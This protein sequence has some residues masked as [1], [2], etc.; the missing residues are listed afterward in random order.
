[1]RRI[2]ILLIVTATL[3]LSGCMTAAER[4]AADDSACA[5]ARD[6]NICRQNIMSHRRDLAIMAQ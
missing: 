6:Y 3:A 1:M 4:E 5:T 2:G